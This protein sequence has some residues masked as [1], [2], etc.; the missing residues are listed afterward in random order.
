MMVNRAFRGLDKVIYKSF[1]RPY[2]EYS[3]C[4]EL[5]YGTHTFL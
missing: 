3:L 4:A 2:S 5:E 1:I